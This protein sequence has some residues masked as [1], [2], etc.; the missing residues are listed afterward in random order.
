MSDACESA[1]ISLS[2]FTVVVALCF[3]SSLCRPIYDRCPYCDML[4]RHVDEK[5]NPHLRACPERI[6]FLA[7]EVAWISAHD[8][9]DYDRVVQ[10]INPV[11]VVE[12][13]PVEM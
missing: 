8:P 13:D 2:V 11:V 4:I 12:Q 3:L 6:R 10:R 7:A 1:I 5:P 9:N